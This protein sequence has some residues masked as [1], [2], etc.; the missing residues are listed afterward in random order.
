MRLFSAVGRS[1][2]DMLVVLCRKLA[3]PTD[4]LAIGLARATAA[5]ASTAA[6]ATVS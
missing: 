2:R 6:L 4:R 3:P 5:L 1:E